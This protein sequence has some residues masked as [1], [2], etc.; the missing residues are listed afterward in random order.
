[1]KTN[2][3]HSRAVRKPPVAIIWSILKVHILQ[4][5]DQNLA[6]IS[7]IKTID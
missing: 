6:K 7:M 3:V 1:M 5:S 2:L 4:W